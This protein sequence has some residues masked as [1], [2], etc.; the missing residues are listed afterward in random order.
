VHLASNTVALALQM[1]SWSARRRGHHVEGALFGLGAIGALTVAGYLGGHLVYV[2]RVG[3]DAEVKLVGDDGWHPACRTDDIV[4]DNQPFGATVEGARVVL[5]RR[6]G[7]VYALAATCTHAGGPLD[8]GEVHGNV[9]VCPWHHSEFCLDTGEV[10]RGPATTPEP[11]YE[12]RL[13]A[14]MIEVRRSDPERAGRVAAVDLTA[15][16]QA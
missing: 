3:V 7:Y 2:Q 5:V 6:G 11:V 8:E 1:R 13:R 10:E 14:G 9:L 15:V 16:A 12:T 4:H